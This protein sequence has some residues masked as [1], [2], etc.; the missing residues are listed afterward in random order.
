MVWE[1]A[2][3]A[4]FQWTAIDDG[5]MGVP[6]Y[7]ETLAKSNPG[8]PAFVESISNSARPIPFLTGQHWRGYPNLKA[9]II[10]HIFKL[11]RRGRPIEIDQPEPGMDKKN[12]TGNTNKPSFSRGLNTSTSIASSD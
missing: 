3:G 6:T 5:L 12:L 2:E 7:V 10:V 4:T 9:A 1:S 8:M 11:C